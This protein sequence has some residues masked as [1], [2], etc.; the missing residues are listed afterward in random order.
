MGGCS[1]QTK[2]VITN[3]KY[4]EKPIT[5][6]VPFSAGGS[7][8]MIA[9][10]MEKHSSKYLGQ[11][12]IITNM[13]GGSGSIAWNEIAGAKADGYTIGITGPGVMLQPIYG[14]TRYHY[15]TALEPLAQIV[16]VPFVLVVQAESPWKNINEL[17]DYAKRHPGEIKY[18][19]AGLGSSSNVVGE[20][21]AQKAGIQ[22]SQV[23]FR[24]DSEGLA[25]LLGGHV[26]LLVTT[27][28]SV[29][30][31]V[32]SKTVRV[33]GVVA[34]QRLTEPIFSNVPT[35]QEQGLDVAFTMWQGIAAPKGLPD[36]VKV[37][38]VQG[39]KNIINDPEFIKNM[40]GLGMKVEYLGPK[41][42]NE[43]WLEDSVRLP[44]IVK[45]TGIAERIA[46]QKK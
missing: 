11:Q 13:T 7:S 35:L 30:E 16:S 22:I 18:S 34:K 19:H 37:K 9:R 42:F 46:A 2:N 29:I 33:L 23:P 3:D 1:M 32:K 17:V 31:H 12:M 36:D 43:Q 27:Y 20:E 26:Q 38:L 14:P 6:I 44:K 24:G 10:A 41:D 45:E 40:Q 15:P 4:P 39:L 25:A 28:P 21:F 8:D 5:I